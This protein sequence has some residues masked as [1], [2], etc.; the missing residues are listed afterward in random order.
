MTVFQ[1]TSEDTREQARGAPALTAEELQAIFDRSGFD[2]ENHP[3]HIVRRV[4]Q[5]AGVH[6]QQIMATENLSPTQFAVLATI[7]KHGAVSQ[8]RLS[9]LTAMDP[10]TGTVVVRK[11]IKQGLVQRDSSPRDGRLSIVSLTEAGKRFTA[12]RL[13]RSVDVG[14][15]LLSELSDEEQTQLLGL[16]KRLYAD[17]GIPELASEVTTRRTA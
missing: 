2:L 4:H 13:G 12:E 14:R 1:N 3:A 10:S 9:R 7:L 5:R 8:S 15:A 11:L 16:L 17:E 6:F